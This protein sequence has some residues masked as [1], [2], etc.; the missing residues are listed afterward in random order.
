MDKSSKFVNKIYLLCALSGD[1]ITK[2]EFYGYKDNTM[3]ILTKE[4]YL[5]WFRVEIGQC[6]MEGY[7]SSPTSFKR[8]IASTA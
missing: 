3:N 8:G 5:N 2:S 4:N 7:V 6:L 1:F